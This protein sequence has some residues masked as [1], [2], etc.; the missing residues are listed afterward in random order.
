[1]DYSAKTIH[2]IDDLSGKDFEL[3]CVK[4]LKKRGYSNLILT[5][6][7]NDYGI[8]IIAESMGLKF[9]IQCKRS[10]SKIGNKAVQEAFS[11]KTYYKCDVAVVV[12]NNYFTRQAIETA[13]ATEVVLWNR[14][15][16][17]K[18]ML[19]AGLRFEKTHYT[20]SSFV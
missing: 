20:N 15:I 8:D 14:N 18:M 17:I 12:T 11:G 19:E 16:L 1:M 6:S 3:L 10:K 9:A 5:P 13:N 7:T 2:G 4:I